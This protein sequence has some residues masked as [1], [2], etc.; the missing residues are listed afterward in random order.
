MFQK[1]ISCSSSPLSSSC[2]EIEVDILSGMPFLNILGISESAGRVLRERIR[3]ALSSC[4][5]SLPARKITVNLVSSVHPLPAEGLDLP[6]ALGIL[7]ADQC[8]PS[9][10]NAVTAVIGSLSLNGAVRPVAGICSMLSRLKEHLDRCGITEILI[11]ADN[12]LE[13]SLIPGFHLRPVHNLE[14]AI[15]FWRGLTDIPAAPPHSVRPVV[16]SLKTLLSIRG[17]HPGKRALAIACCGYHNLL[18]AGPPG[19]G[20]T[21]LAQ[22]APSLLPAPSADEIRRIL[23]FQAQSGALE[24]PLLS[25]PVRRPHYSIAVHALIGGG[26]PVKPGELTLADGGVLILDELAEFSRHVLE[27]LRQ[28]LESH[29]VPLHYLGQSESLPADFMLIATTNLCPCGLFP[30]PERCHCSSTAIRRYQGRIGAP[31]LERFELCLD[32]EPV[33]ES[34]QSVYSEEEALRLRD[35]ILQAALLQQE[36][37]RNEPF[38]RNSRIPPDRIDTYCALDDAASALFRRAALRYGLSLRTQHN[39]RKAA[40]SIADLAA[41]DIIRKEHIAEALQYRPKGFFSI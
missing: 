13:A 22:A 41:S 31:L 10:K 21:L 40:R 32:L 24:G 18:L 5:Y 28:P 34:Q 35:R 30:D 1:I 7:C 11:P 15:L 2:I 17:Q 20:K 8:L 23:L 39:I 29:I 33:P 14:E 19:C 3:S 27:N 25:R 16:P 37:Y 9:A 6:I 26:R 38:D 36:R 4:G 12:A